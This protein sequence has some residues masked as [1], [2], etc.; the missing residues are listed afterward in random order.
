MTG[1]MGID[2]ALRSLGAAL[3]DGRL[4]TIRPRADGHDDKLNEIDSLI[5][6]LLYQHTPDLVLVEGPAPHGPGWQAKSTLDEVRGIVRLAVRHHGGPALI[7]GPSRLKR[8]ATGNG[9]APKEL[10]VA[11]A[12]QLGHD[13]RNDDEADAA[14]LRALGLHGVTGDDPFRDRDPGHR[15]DVISNMTWPLIAR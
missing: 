13:P 4:L 2:P 15:L 12:R 9:N 7:V 1:V 14:L 3:P 8:Y 5:R 11:A 10:M 6:G